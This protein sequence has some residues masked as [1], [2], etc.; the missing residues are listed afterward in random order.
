LTID[1]HSILNNYLQMLNARKL[2]DTLRMRNAKNLYEGT[3]ES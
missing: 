2:R 3:Y 1:R